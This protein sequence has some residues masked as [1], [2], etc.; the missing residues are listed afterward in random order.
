MYLNHNG[1]KLYWDRYKLL[2]GDKDNSN[3]LELIKKHFGFNN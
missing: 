3:F 1:I 2:G